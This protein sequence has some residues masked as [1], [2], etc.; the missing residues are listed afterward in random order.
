MP[1]IKP[2]IEKYNQKILEKVQVKHSS[3]TQHCNCTN[4]KHCLLNAQCITEILST[5][6]K[7]IKLAIKVQ[8]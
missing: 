7:V 2:E 4:K 6:I 8:Y 1:N 3:N 5:S